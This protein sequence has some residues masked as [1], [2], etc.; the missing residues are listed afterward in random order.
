MVNF[1]IPNSTLVVILMNG[2]LINWT[3]SGYFD[4]SVGQS[5]VAQSLTQT[6]GQ[7]V[8]FGASCLMPLIDYFLMSF[9]INA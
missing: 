5:A 8:M 1:R 3:C 2:Q 7:A 9:V 6:I 4:L